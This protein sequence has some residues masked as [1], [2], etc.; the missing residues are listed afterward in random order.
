MFYLFT[1]ITVI[2]FITVIHDNT[3]H[4][5]LLLLALL[6]KYSPCTEFVLGKAIDYKCQFKINLMLLYFIII[7]LS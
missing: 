5:I 4:L 7:C 3:L 2:L 1:S 6:T